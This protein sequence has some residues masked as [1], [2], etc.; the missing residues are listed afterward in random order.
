MAPDNYRPPYYLGLVAR[1]QER[2]DEA[3]AYFDQ[4]LELKPDNPSMLYQKAVTLKTMGRL[5]DAITQL[6]QAIDLHKNP[7]QSWQDLLAKW[8][9]EQ[10]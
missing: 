10:G 5:N 7:P 3:L 9:A 1:A 6:Q 4:S 2:Y 8:Q